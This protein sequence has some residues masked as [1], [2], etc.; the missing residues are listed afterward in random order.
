[1]AV[2]AVHDILNQVE[3]F[4]V[5]RL[6]MFQEHVPP[7]TSQQQAHMPSLLS[8]L[9]AS[10]Q[11]LA[12]GMLSDLQRNNLMCGIL[13]GSLFTGCIIAIIAILRQSG[14]C[15]A[16]V[17]AVQAVQ[18]SSL[19]IN[20]NTPA[21]HRFRLRR[22]NQTSI[23]DDLKISGLFLACPLW[24]ILARP[25]LG[26]VLIACRIFQDPEIA[27]LVAADPEFEVD[28]RMWSTDEAR[29]EQ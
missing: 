15:T 17:A 1:M 26:F 14:R 24:C 28:L 2:F 12:R 10:A 29:G 16:L 27:D 4:R 22:S 9:G 6:Q 11:L 25:Y 5:A 3:H 8:S 13:L 20:I 18:P 19:S 7:Q 23:Y 21:R